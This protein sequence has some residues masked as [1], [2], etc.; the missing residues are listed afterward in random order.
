[1]TIREAIDHNRAVLADGGP[2]LTAAYQTYV[3]ARDR[4]RGQVLVGGL[5][6]M[7]VGRM[8]VD[9]RPEHARLPGYADA[10]EADSTSEID[11]DDELT[12]E[13]AGDGG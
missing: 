8:W 4:A 9:E 13:R 12:R 5:G 7:G 6:A 3:A 11:L 1:M 10:P 2:R